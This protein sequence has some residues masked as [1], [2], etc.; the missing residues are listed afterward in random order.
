MNKLAGAIMKI[1][2]FKLRPEVLERQLGIYLSKEQLARLQ[3]YLDQEIENSYVLQHP[4]KTGIP[5][6][7][8]APLVASSNAYERAKV[9]LLRGDAKLQEQVRKAQL[10]KAITDLMSTVGDRLSNDTFDSYK[11]YKGYR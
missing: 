3:T 5:T 7:G 1:A 8:I 9:N 10:Q 11:G 2:K 4:Y 6:L